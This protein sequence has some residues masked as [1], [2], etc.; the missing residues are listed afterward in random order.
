MLQLALTRCLIASIMW[1]NSTTIHSDQIYHRCFERTQEGNGLYSDVPASDPKRGM[2]GY[3]DQFGDWKKIVDLTDTADLT[4]QGLLLPEH[5]DI[6]PS[7]VK[8]TA[9]VMESSSMR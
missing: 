7:Q 6:G 8:V 9:N 2:C 1:R 4:S 3:F 5:V